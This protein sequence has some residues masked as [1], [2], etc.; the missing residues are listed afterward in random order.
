M[1]LFI[2]RRL[3]VT[4]LLLIVISVLIFG[5]IQLTPG[6]AVDM[7]LGGVA[8]DSLGEETV[9][10]LRR[11]LGLDLPVYQQYFNWIKGVLQ[12]DMG[13][14][15]IMKAPVGPIILQR[16]KTSLLLAVPASLM[17]VFFGLTLG[18][19]SAVKENSIIDH[20]ISFSTL[21]MISIPAFLVGSIFIY[22]FSVKL[23]WIPAAFNALPFEQ[24]PFWRRVGFFFTV[25][26]FPSLTLSFE[27]VAY[28]AR[29]TRASM[30]EE[31]KTN[32]VRTAVLKGVRPQRVITSH[33]LRNAL[34]P[35]ITVIAFN[36]GYIL[37]GVVIV[38]AVFS[39]PG[40]GNLMV[41]AI[42]NRDTPLILGTMLII[43]GAYVLANFIA[44]I[45]YSVFNPRIEY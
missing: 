23:N 8:Q 24:Y 35:A 5:I 31:L 26:I 41:I 7:M 19:W 14:S 6:D 16:L 1:S 39:Y 11:Q 18:V 22:I 4:V 38:E 29:Q 17:M 3:G 27:S 36:I 37:A 40:I 2:L 10:T 9:E 30:I 28:V 12:G 20:F 21:S 43:A 44:D 32:Y 34:L 45:L 13:T 15:L 33:A 42:N 25:L